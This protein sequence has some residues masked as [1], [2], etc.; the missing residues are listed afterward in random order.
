MKPPHAITLTRQAWSRGSLAVVVTACFVELAV[1][2]T[3]VSEYGYHGDE[4]YFLDCGRHLAFGYV[5]HAPLVPWLARLSEALGGGLFPLRLP[6]ILA[7]AGTLFLSAL[8]VH[9]WGGQWRAQMITLVAML[10]A[11]RSSA[12]ERC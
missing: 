11:P 12:F 8:L 4:L 3:L 2:V 5:D 1:H 6:A 9:E 7:G 10:V